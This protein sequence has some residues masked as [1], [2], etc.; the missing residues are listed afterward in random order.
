[1]HYICN[2]PNIIF[3]LTSSRFTKLFCFAIFL[4]DLGECNNSNYSVLLCKVTV[5]E[6]CQGTI[7]PDRLLICHSYCCGYC[8]T[9]HVLSSSSLLTFMFHLISLLFVG[10]YDIKI[11]SCCLFKCRASRSEFSGLSSGSDGVRKGSM[12]MHMQ[13][14][15]VSIQTQTV[16]SI[17]LASFCGDAVATTLSAPWPNFHFGRKY[18]QQRQNKPS[19]LEML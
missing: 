6:A 16:V 1:M 14:G 17:F 8:M 11:L 5:R 10:V 18:R 12:R 2:H 9:V 19:I 13:K 3:F 4:S 7:F 15:C